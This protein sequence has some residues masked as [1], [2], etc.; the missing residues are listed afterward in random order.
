MLGL[1]YRFSTIGVLATLTYFAISSMLIMME[2]KPQIASLG[3][4]FVGFLISFFGQMKYTYRVKRATLSNYYRFIS[5][6]LFGLLLSQCVI[7]VFTLNNWNS[8]VG[9]LFNCVA[10]P[11]INFFAT[12]CWVFTNSAQDSTSTTKAPPK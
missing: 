1:I 11:L 4:Y 6:S 2:V 8:S 10:I 9:I 5:L 12:K 3:G 7:W